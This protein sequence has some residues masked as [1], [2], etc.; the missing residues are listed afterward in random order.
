M[1]EKRENCIISRRWRRECGVILRI[2]AFHH[3]L[4]S[5]DFAPMIK[6][7]AGLS[8]GRYIVHS[9]PPPPLAACSPIYHCCLE[10]DEP[11][12]LRINGCHAVNI[13]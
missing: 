9:S 1:V 4:Y 11:S 7:T 8:G 12:S 2:S 5:P 3:S 10:I 6:P 13:K